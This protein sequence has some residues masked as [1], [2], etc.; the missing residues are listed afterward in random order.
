M[1]GSYPVFARMN[2]GFGGAEINLYYI[3]RELAK[4]PHYEVK[5]VVGDYGQD[6]QMVMD[7]VGIIRV[8]HL[9]PERFPSYF[10]KIVSRLRFCLF[11]W[12]DNS[13]IYVCS[14][15]SDF[16][17]YVVLFGKI[18]RGKRVIFRTG[19]DW[20]IN[21]HFTRSKNLFGL[22]YK[23][24]LHRADAIITQNEHQQV[25]LKRTENLDS[26]V[27]RNGFPISG[28]QPSGTREYLLWI[29]RA[30]SFKRPELFIRLAQA[31]PSHR[32]V[33]ILSGSG[34]AKDKI[35]REAEA[36][37]NLE[38]RDGV[39]FFESIAYF[40]K[41]K[42]LVNTSSAE[43]FPNTFIQAGLTQTPILSFAVNPDNMLEKHNIGFC[44]SDNLEAAKKF[45]LS[46]NDEKIEQLGANAFNYI[47][48]YHNIEDK[49][50]QYRQIITSLYA[51]L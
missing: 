5:F 24:A 16:L 29:A 9:N 45:V 25:T 22:M 21:G 35:T 38:F 20:D 2:N 18:L 28:E 39:S 44:C 23:L 19:H 49:I 4:D 37:G 11:V 31:L 36:I 30:D 3:S 43:G 26:V 15:A 34:P 41:A 1:A 33:M 40:R 13:D 14:T 27:I 32:F 6:P 46:L 48:T 47:R 12:R 10:H 50:Q 7:N 51:N 42:C 8:R 17:A